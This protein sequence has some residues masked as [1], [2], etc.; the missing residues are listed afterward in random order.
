MQ[1]RVGVK[2]IAIRDG[3]LLVV[4]KRVAN[5]VIYSFPGDAKV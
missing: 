2:A 5:G 3:K 1:P 4:R